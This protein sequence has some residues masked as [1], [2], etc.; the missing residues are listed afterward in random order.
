MRVIS[1]NFDDLIIV[2]LEVFEDDR[3]Y[4]VETYAQDWFFKELSFKSILD[5]EVKSKKNVLR[6][7]HYQ[8][9]PYAQAKIIKI[10]EG[11]VLDVVVDLRK[12][13]R[14]FGKSFSTELSSDT[15]KLIYIPR[16]FAHGYCVLSDVAVMTYKLDNIF[17]KE[18]ARGIAYNDKTL[19][20]DWTINGN[21]ILSEQDKNFPTLEVA[22][23]KM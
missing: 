17:C 16:G 15:Q 6:G 18:Y 1:T 10:I 11:S 13:S 21:P 5:L 9:E 2:E 19:D 8:E 3:G 14:T 4:L 12:N 20:I 7:L 22:T 23:S